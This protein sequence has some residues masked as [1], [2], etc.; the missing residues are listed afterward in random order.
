MLSPAKIATASALAG[1]GMAV[2]GVYLLAGLGWALLAAAAPLLLLA[3]V[4]MRGL[5]RVG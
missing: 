5:L 1:T 4:L 3:A 2:A